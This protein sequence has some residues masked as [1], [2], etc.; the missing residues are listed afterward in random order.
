LSNCPRLISFLLTAIIPK[1]APYTTTDFVWTKEP[2][3]A[4]F[5]F[6][7]IHWTDEMERA[8][9]K[10]CAMPEV[11]LSIDLFHV[12]LLFFNPDIREKQHYAIVPA[13]WKPWR[14][15]LWGR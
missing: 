13:V 6:A 8:W 5:V 15:G 3:E 9:Q 1:A 12:G 7:D 10:L 4:V 2:Q 14:M 11:T